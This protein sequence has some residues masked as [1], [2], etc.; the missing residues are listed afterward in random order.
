MCDRAHSN[1]A[2]GGSAISQALRDP[3]HVPVSDSTALT[4]EVRR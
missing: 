2:E 4:K 3:R 1:T